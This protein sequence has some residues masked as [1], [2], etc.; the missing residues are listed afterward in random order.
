[1]RKW[2]SILHP[3]I[4]PWRNPVLPAERKDLTRQDDSAISVWAIT[5]RCYQVVYLGLFSRPSISFAG[6]A[7]PPRANFPG[8]CHLT[9]PPL[10]R[11]CIA[12]GWVTCS[13]HGDRAPNDETGARKTCSAIFVDRCQAL[14]NR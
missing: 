3:K 1:M 13:L 10:D 8:L 5:C 4:E 14:R 11:L 9:S 2:P 7:V 6:P 12:D